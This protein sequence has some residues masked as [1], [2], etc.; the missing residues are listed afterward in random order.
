MG[1]LKN[2]FGFPPDV[3]P[4]YRE[5]VDYQLYR[6]VRKTYRIIHLFILGFQIIMMT[7]MATRPGGPFLHPRRT[8]YS[9]LYA[10]LI[11]VTLCA[12]LTDYLLHR[13]VRG[14]D[15]KTAAL[16]V[17]CRAYVHIANIYMVL[18]CLWATGITLNDQLGGNGLNVF[19]YMTLVVA[20]LSVMRPWQSAL[21]FGF[22]FVLL[23]LLLPYFPVPGGADQTFNNLM[24]SLAFSSMA[25]FLSVFFYHSKVTSEYNKIVIRDQYEQIRAANQQLH[26]EVLNDNLTGLRNRRYLEDV[27][28]G[29]FQK[30]WEEQTPAACMM[31]DI[32]HFKQYNDSY[33]HQAGDQCL[34]GV[35]RLLTRLP[36]LQDAD[37]IRYGGEEFLLF[38]FGDS[39]LT[40][41]EKARRLNQDLKNQEPSLEAGDIGRITISI[42]VHQ[43]VPACKSRDIAHFIACADQALYEAKKSGRDRTVVYRE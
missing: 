13:P 28:S 27:V 38:F 1:K 20:V 30:S 9:S 11:L 16:R 37:K 19:L 31:I 4:K 3:D 15:R 22:N 33:G 5:Q 34:I 32:D 21:L 35:A 2:Y 18:V 23:N 17:S 10:A 6:Y 40:A 42:G 8:M 43:E 7:S 36:Y 39:A 14:G 41:D 12:M 26:Q 29:R 24:N 25:I